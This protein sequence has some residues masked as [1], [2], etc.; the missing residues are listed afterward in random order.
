ML[1]IEKNKKL[2]RIRPVDPAGRPSLARRPS[3]PAGLGLTNLKNKPKYVKIEL[4]K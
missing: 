3:L 4:V 1:C 2:D